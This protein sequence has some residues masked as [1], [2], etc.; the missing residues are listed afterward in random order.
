MPRD[1]V[2][3]RRDARWRIL[4]HAP[5]EAYAARARV[6]LAHLGYAILTEAE[7]EA[8][9]PKQAARP[10]ALRVLE[11]G[12]L[13]DLGRAEAG[14][15]LVAI[16]AS[17]EPVPE[18]PRLVGAV[19]RPAALHPLFRLLQQALEAT[20]RATPRVPTHLPAR[21]RAQDGDAWSAALLSLSEGGALLRSTR[22]VPLG[23]EL[24]LGFAL[25]RA[26]RLV[27]RGEAAYRL[28]PD[29]GVV[30]SGV[31]PADRSAIAAFVEEALGEGPVALRAPRPRS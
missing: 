7:W 18:D 23:T 10:P 29:V 9:P 28:P 2:R 8:L 20:P 12:R 6:L 31:A 21:C 17:G 27:L 26:G 15:P 19:A 5:E 30:F 11:A 22:P 24:E 3:P 13:A 25:P 14:A 16:A 1:P 4:S